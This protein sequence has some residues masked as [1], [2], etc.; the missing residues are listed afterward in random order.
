MRNL[1]NGLAAHLAS[2]ATSL[3]HCWRVIRRDGIVLG[4]TDHDVDVTASG[5]LCVARSGVEGAQA[6][7]ALGFAVG[8]S[9]IAGA[10]ISQMLDEADLANGVYDGASVEV[11]LVNWQDPSQ[12][13]LLDMGTIGQITRSEFA[14]TAEVRTLAH[15]FD[16]ERGRYFQAGCNAD[17][18]DARCKAN[19][20]SPTFIANDVVSATDGRIYLG[21]GLA[22]YVS[23]WFTGG[24]LTFLSG[25]NQGAPFIVKQHSI[26]GNLAAITLW[27]PTARPI[28]P[29]DNFQISAGCDK[30]FATCENKFANGVNFRGFPHMPGNDQILSFPNQAD[31]AMDGGSLFR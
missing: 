16:Q 4:F 30:F 14:F 12:N 21:A 15:E 24:E 25:A 18:G 29:G 22:G 13:L 26:M 3:C 10:L 6:E 20:T 19:L 8:G 28:L 31:L 17:L 1:P 2:G 27:Q 23:D 9:E 11:W 7:T 5:T